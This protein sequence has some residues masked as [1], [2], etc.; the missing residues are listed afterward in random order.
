MLVTNFTTR[1][2]SLTGGDVQCQ[3]FRDGDFGG[4]GRN[5]PA[6]V[7]EIGRPD[8][9]MLGLKCLR[10]VQVAQRNLGRQN[11]KSKIAVYKE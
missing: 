10:S 9:S 1:A 5:V 8:H 11:D 2:L 3:S 6:D 7:F 4:R